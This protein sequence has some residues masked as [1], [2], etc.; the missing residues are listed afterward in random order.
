MFRAL[1]QD[2][3]TL[4]EVLE[5]V[6]PAHL[7][8]GDGK[9]AMDA[10]NLILDVAQKMKAP[11][12]EARAWTFVAAG[13]FMSKSEDAAEA[14]R[15]ALDLCRSGRHRAGEVQTLLELAK[16]QLTLQDCRLRT[17]RT[18]EPV[19]GGGLGFLVRL[20]LRPRSSEGGARRRDLASGGPCSRSH[21]GGVGWGWSACNSAGWML[22]QP[23]ALDEAQ[24]QLSSLTPAASKAAAAMMSAVVV[25][26]AALKGA[27]AGLERVK[28]YIM[29]PS[30]AMA[31]LPV[32]RGTG[33][34]RAARPWK[35]LLVAST[36][37][38]GCHPSVG[39]LPSARPRR[40]QEPHVSVRRL[41]ELRFLFA[42]SPTEL[43]N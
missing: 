12:V 42:S 3:P 38:A 41:E 20:G 19:A 36:V 4:A 16:G 24:E 32:L 17:Q 40:S 6:A 5:V 13:R 35:V 2:W 11:E 43:Q 33:R 9:K 29:S 39:F 23:A 27:D 15:K 1:L 37:L 7:H 31:A 18:G 34:S 8:R 14:A 30:S 26:T 22:F 10:A 28:G 25:A 21:R